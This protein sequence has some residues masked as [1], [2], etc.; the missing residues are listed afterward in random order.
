M[1]KFIISAE[2]A[3]SNFVLKNPPNSMYVITQVILQISAE[4]KHTIQFLYL[5]CTFSL[6]G[7][8]YDQ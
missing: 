1:L 5:H 6:W 8:P 3:R 2:N 7:S 4:I